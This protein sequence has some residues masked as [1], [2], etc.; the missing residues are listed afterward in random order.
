M[1]V[2]DSY[3]LHVDLVLDQYFGHICIPEGGSTTGSL[4]VIREAMRRAYG[5]LHRHIRRK[6]VSQEQRMEM[7]VYATQ[8]IQLRNY[9][10]YVRP[11]KKNPRYK[12]MQGI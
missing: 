8:A 10:L 11:V 4:D 9:Q 2:P 3:K 7:R 5:Q 6:K 12:G 1:A